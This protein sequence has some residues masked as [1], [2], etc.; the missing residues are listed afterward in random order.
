MGFSAAPAFSLRWTSILHVW[1]GVNPQRSDRHCQKAEPYSSATISGDM[2]KTHQHKGGSYT[3]NR[4][5]SQSDEHTSTEEC[6]Q[7]CLLRVRLFGNI[8][9]GSTLF[10][11][12]GAHKLGGHEHAEWNVGLQLR[13]SNQRGRGLAWWATWRPSSPAAHCWRIRECSL[14]GD[15][16]HLQCIVFHHGTIQFLNC[17]KHKEEPGLHTWVE[18]TLHTERT[19]PLLHST[20]ML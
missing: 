15:V 13:A 20:I 18:K 2:S 3:A 4:L 11:D 19:L 14:I 1:G 6:N 8:T 16:A 12:D 17:S 7:S 9:D 5:T 10:A